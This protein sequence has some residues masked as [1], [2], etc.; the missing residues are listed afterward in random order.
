MAVNKK[1][2]DIMSLEELADVAITVCVQ[3]RTYREAPKGGCS[4]ENTQYSRE[5]EINCSYFSTGKG[6]VLYGRGKENE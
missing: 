3:N 6:C 4:Y 1:Q 5:I 2:S